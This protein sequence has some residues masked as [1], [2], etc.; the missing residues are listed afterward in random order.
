MYI[1]QVTESQ[2]D[3]ITAKYDAHFV[4]TILKN[5]SKE[6]NIEYFQY[7]KSF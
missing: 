3:K 7:A 1:V 2:C 4:C 6:L 5:E